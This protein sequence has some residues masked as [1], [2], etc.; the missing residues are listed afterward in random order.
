MV[1]NFLFV[2][3]ILRIGTKKDNLADTSWQTRLLDADDPSRPH[4]QRLVDALATPFS[5]GPFMQGE[6][7]DR[8]DEEVRNRVVA[9]PREFAGYTYGYNHACLH[10]GP[11]MS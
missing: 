8:A 4:I 11:M 7:L 5:G 1:K 3:S 6:F 10:S 2:G 9:N